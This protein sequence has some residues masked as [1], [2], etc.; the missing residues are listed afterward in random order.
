MPLYYLSAT[1]FWIASATL[2]A[3]RS[4]AVRAAVAAALTA[5]LILHA[6]GFFI[7]M[8]PYLEVAR[9]S[10]NFQTALEAIRHEV[11]RDPPSVLRFQAPADQPRPTSSS[12]R[13]P[14]RPCA[15]AYLAPPG[16]SAATL[17]ALRRA[18]NASA[19]GAGLQVRLHA[20]LSLQALIPSPF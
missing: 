12:W 6:T 2:D 11:A 5:A 14:C 7:Q 4:R 3:G 8:P 19:S 18:I 16:A 9:L 17:D 1:L 10:R 20:D 15:R 13:P